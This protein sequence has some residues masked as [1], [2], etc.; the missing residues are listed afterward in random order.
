[1]AKH[2]ETGVVG[3]NIVTKYLE[4]KGFSVIDRNYNKKWG[5]LDI[6]AQKGGLVHFGR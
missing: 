2:N 5:E 4:N 3:E 1:M 6:I